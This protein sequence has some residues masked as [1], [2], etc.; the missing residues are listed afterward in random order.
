MR[1]SAAMIVGIALGLAL[2][3]SGCGGDGSSAA[4]EPASLA[5][6]NREPAP[7]KAA[8]ARPCRQLSGFIASMTA[9]RDRLARGLSYDDYLGEVQGVRAL[10]GDIEAAKLTVGC[11]VVSGGPSERAFNLY[12][13]GA[14]IW[15]DC[16]A[17]V[18]CTP[19]SIEPRLQ[20]KWALAAQQLT[21]AKRGLHRA[22]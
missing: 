1:L 22:P 5:S 10:Y 18:S 17:T 14:N 6:T 15:G 19:R 21:V 11:L 7:R 8:P 20:R 16:L 4:G 3:V 13:D 2:M 9:L 12:I